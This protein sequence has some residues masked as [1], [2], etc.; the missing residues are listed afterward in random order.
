M[1]NS[2]S[3]PLR[4]IAPPPVMY[5]G[6]LLLGVAIHVLSPIAIFPA[7]HAHEILGGFLLALSGAFARWAFLTMRRLGT[8]AN[9][10]KPSEA[11]ATGG[12]FRISR[13]PIYVAMTGL[14][15]GLAFLVNSAWLFILLAPLLMFMQW[16]VILREERYL[17]GKFGNEYAAYSSRVRRWL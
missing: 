10:K 6:A 11:L 15:I 7:T 9:P 14:Y 12:P 1:S 16:G 3:L 4:L 8:T 5:I 2:N 17:S 13:N